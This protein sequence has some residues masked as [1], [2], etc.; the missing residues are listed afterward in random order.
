MRILEQFDGALDRSSPGPFFLMIISWKI[1]VCVIRVDS[2]HLFP[3][4]LLLIERFYGGNIFERYFFWRCPVYTL[5][6]E[7]VQICFGEY[8]PALFPV[9]DS[10]WPFEEGSFFNFMAS[11]I[12]L[13]VLSLH[14]TNTPFFG[15]K[16]HF[17]PILSLSTSIDIF[18][19]D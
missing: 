10:P 3:P 11:H 2:K 7:R 19:L 6:L 18:L 13:H 5:S 8:D 15:I 4:V 16:N 1:E 14:Y 12:C 17:N 9:L